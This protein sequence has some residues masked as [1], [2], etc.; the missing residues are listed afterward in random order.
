M[1]TRTHTSYQKRTL[2]TNKKSRKVWGKLKVCSATIST[3]LVILVAL[4]GVFYLAQINHL[5]IKGYE[6]KDLERQIKESKDQ[7]ERLEYEG[8]QTGSLA[9]VQKRVAELGLVSSEEVD[10]ISA[11]VSTVAVKD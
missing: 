6:M 9:V 7:E 10:Y 8:L 3:F 4:V 5:M 1:T 11:G 2:K